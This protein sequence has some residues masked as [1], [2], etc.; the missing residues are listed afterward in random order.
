M[1]EIE[2]DI[3]EAI[4]KHTPFSA[5]EIFTE[6]QTIKSFDVIL[7][8]VDFSRVFGVSIHEAMN[9]LLAEYIREQKGK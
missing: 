2:K 3:C 9:H 6:W 7:R 4:A 5:D 1:N 8:A